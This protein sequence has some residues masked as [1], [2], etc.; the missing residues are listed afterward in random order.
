MRKKDTDQVYAM[1]TLVKADV[2]QKQ[3]AAHVKAERDILSEANSPW[4]VK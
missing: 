4:I 3:Q 2:I 1:K